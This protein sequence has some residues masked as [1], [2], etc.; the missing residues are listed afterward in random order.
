MRAVQLETNAKYIDMALNNYLV[1]CAKG[2]R[3]DM[4]IENRGNMQT[5]LI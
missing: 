3:N 5:I 2:V 4:N 1:K